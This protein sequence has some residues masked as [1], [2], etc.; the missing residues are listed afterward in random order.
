MR[1]SR[2]SMPTKSKKYR[3]HMLETLAMY[4][5]EL[6]E[7]LLAEEEPYR[8]ADSQSH[9]ASRPTSRALRPFS[10]LGL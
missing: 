10:G 4:S 6:M 3:H 8:R 5:D 9:Q 7:L 1:R 2:P